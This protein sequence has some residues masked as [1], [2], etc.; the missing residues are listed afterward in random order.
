MR[1]RRFSGLRKRACEA[2][3]VRAY[4][5]D[6]RTGWHGS[7]DGVL[8]VLD[9]DG[10]RLDEEDVVSGL[11]IPRFDDTVVTLEPFG[12]CRSSIGSRTAGTRRPHI[13]NQNL[14]ND[15][16]I[17]SQHTNVNCNWMRIP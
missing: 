10:L 7:G 4:R 9:E 11:G 8:L 13:P 15:V 16:A 1:G 17:G 2:V 12:I 5:Q 6:C 3:H 14:D